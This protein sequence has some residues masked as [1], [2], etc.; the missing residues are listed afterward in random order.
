MSSIFITDVEGTGVFSVPSSDSELGAATVAFNALLSSVSGLSYGGIYA[1]VKTA[2]GSSASR[3][4]NCL[5]SGMT[6]FGEVCP[7]A[8]EVETLTSQIESALLSSPSLDSLNIQ[9]V[10]LVNDSVSADISLPGLENTLIVDKGSNA[11]EEG[12]QQKPFHTVQAALDEA[13]AGDT[14]LVYPG[15]YTENLSATENVSI[16]GVDPEACSIVQSG[17]GP[18]LRLTASQEVSFRNVSLTGEIEV[19]GAG[20]VL[21]LL[22]DSSLSGSVFVSAGDSSTAVTIDGADLT[23]T[24]SYPRPIVISDA[25]PTVSVRGGSRVVGLA[26]SPAVYWGG[27]V[28]NDNFSAKYSVFVHGDGAANN[29]FEVNG[30]QTPQYRSHHNAYNSDPE[31][32]GTFTNTISPGQRFDTFDALATY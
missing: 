30:G 25:D 2:D 28:T 8:T 5:L 9:E 20:S 4:L 31:S 10:N 14:V 26:G 3:T 21:G 15:V 7:D 16:V 11:I 19:A 6:Y 27:G 13:S 12:T 17:S 24:S 1:W 18:L 22:P 23:G 29:P 32:G